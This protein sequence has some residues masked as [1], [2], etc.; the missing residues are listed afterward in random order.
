MNL[1]TIIWQVMTPLALALIAHAAL[2]P[3]TYDISVS[4]AINWH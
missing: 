2:L 4:I 3:S 1:N